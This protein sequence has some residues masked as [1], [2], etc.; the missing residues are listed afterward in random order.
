MKLPQQTVCW[1]AALWLSTASVA[2]QEES[3]DDLLGGF[4]EPPTQAEPVDDLLG[5]FDDE[6][7]D[8]LTEGFD[9][10]LNFAPEPIDDL[11]GGFDAPTDPVAAED[12]SPLLPTG[13]AGSAGM[14]LSYAYAQKAP[15]Q[16]APDYRGLRKLR[17]FLQLEYEYE[18]SRRTS[19]FIDGKA[20][21]DLAYQFVDRDDYSDAYLKSYEQ[22]AELRETFF[23]TSFGSDVDF[24]FGRQIKVWGKADLLSAVDVLNPTDNREPGLIDIDDSRLP[25][26]MTQ[27]D[28]YTGDWNLN[29]V[30][31]HEI[32][33]GKEPEFGSEFY[34]TE[35][36]LPPEEI[37]TDTEY[38]VALNGYFS[39]WDLSVYGASVYNDA[40]RA[41]GTFN[42]DQNQ[43][44]DRVVHDRLQVIGAAFSAVEGSWILRGELA[45]VQG[46]RFLGFDQSFSR[47]DHVLGV[48]FSGIPEGSLSVEV[49]WEWLRDYA[50]GLR[51]EPN[52]QKRDTV[53]TAIR[54]QQ[55]FLNQTLSLNAIA[56]QFGALGD[57]GSSQRLGLDYDWA[58]GLNVAGGVLLYQTGDSDYAKRIADNDRLYADVKYSF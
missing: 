26:T 17:L 31:I 38:G 51:K 40:G 11:L 19:F 2:A 21:Q 7:S 43:F 6:A 14:N 54:F 45:D 56:F 52:S 28:Y 18:F 33:F 55:D 53:T 57:S 36:K 10:E 48:E 23:A 1:L 27:L 24:K 16:D 46:L 32:R 5:G 13:L 20:S 22:E 9:D 8:D 47:Q 39:G 30:V 15:R 58:D 29:L 49:A 37:P 35:T 34:F 3:L 50:P 12:P 4:D 41:A 42:P 25:V 44:P